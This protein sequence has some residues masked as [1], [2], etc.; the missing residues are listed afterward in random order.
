VLRKVEYFSS[1]HFDI[2]AR[3]GR[4]LLRFSRLDANIRGENVRV[5]GT[6]T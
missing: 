4:K 2:L 3:V 6:G 1:S 5:S